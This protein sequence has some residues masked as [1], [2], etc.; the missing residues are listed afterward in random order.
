VEKRGTRHSPYLTVPFLCSSV[1]RP[2][3]LGSNPLSPCTLVPITSIPIPLTRTLFLAPLPLSPVPCSLSL[4]HYSLPSVPYLPSSILWHFY[5]IFCPLTPIPVPY[6][7]SSFL[8]TKS[9]VP[10]YSIPSWFLKQGYLLFPSPSPPP[11][12]PPQYR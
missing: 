7:L 3:S 2:L 1:S 11:P 5:P 10:L 12:R 6:P 8:C 4:F 9:T